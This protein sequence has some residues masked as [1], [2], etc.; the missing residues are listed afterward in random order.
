MEK[1]EKSENYIDRI[2]TRFEKMRDLRNEA[3]EL[4]YE[5]ID[6]ENSIKEAKQCSERIGRFTEKL[7]Q[8]QGGCGWDIMV[9]VRK[10]STSTEHEWTELYRYHMSNI[11]DLMNLIEDRLYKELE[12]AIYYVKKS[13]K[14]IAKTTD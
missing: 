12:D 11:D 2:R 10:G 1:E 6:A 4:E 3:K 5:L 7:Q 9:C 13:R 8:T 14:K